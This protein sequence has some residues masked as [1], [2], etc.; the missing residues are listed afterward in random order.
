MATRTY[1]SQFSIHYLILYVNTESLSDVN[2]SNEESPS[3]TG[4]KVRTAIK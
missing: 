3:K 4:P 1:T 2:D